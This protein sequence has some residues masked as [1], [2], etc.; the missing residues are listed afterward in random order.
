VRV[1]VRG[2]TLVGSQGQRVADVLIEDGVIA[3]LE[4]EPS[5]AASADAAVDASGKLVFPGF[6]DPHVHSRDPGATHKEDF[7]HSTRAAA[8]GGVTCILEMPNA[9]PAVAG[10][11]TFQERAATHAPNAFVDFGLW[12]L[13][14]GM[15]NL[16]ELGPMFEA[17]AVGMKLFWGYTLHLGTKELIYNLSDAAPEEILPP[18]THGEV[19]EVF[20]GVAQ[21]GGLLA[22]H[23]EERSV[24]DTALANLGHPV[25]TYDDLLAVRPEVAEAASIALGVE[26]ARATGCRF[27]VVHM[28]SRRGTEIIREAQARGVSASAETCPHYLTLTD[29]SFGIVGPA[30]KVYP[31]VREATH[32]E[33]LWE[34]LRDGTIASVGSDHAPHTIE[35]KLRPLGSQPSGTV[36]VETLAPVMVDT[37]LRGRISPERLAWVLSEGTARLYGLY[38]RKGSLRPGS[39]ADLTLVDP[40]VRRTVRNIGL[41]SKQ[42]LSPWDGVVLQGWPIMAILRGQ[43]IMRDGEPVGEPA[44]RFI[45]AFRSAGP[46]PGALDQHGRVTTKR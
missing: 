23:C 15:E 2:G 13:S 24:L 35:E 46:L 27:H 36:G 41:H 20:R 29:A 19:L 44:G 43:V 33:A 11:M 9:V 39:D 38:P 22:A 8:A 45:P 18:P 12:G 31:P 17:G 40:S 30:M 6:I 3:A 25:E 37:M 42:P 7:A 4:P 34:G 16:H 26:F 1:L 14:L 28:S 5:A 10:V 21:S 32:Q